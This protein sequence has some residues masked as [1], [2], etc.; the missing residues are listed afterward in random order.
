MR[1]QC[2]PYSV[3]IARGG[4]LCYSCIRVAGGGGGLWIK[5]IGLGAKSAIITGAPN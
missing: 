1:S 4:T 2:K 3:R 5:G